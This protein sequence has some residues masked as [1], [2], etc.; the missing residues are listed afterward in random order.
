MTGPR[1]DPASPSPTRLDSRS[2][3]ARLTA[4]API[5]TLVAR[6]YLLRTGAPRCFPVEFVAA[7][8]L[9]APPTSSGEGV[10][11]VVLVDSDEQREAAIQAVALRAPTPGAR[12][13]IHVIPDEPWPLLELVGQH[14]AL[15]GRVREQLRVAREPAAIR[16]L[17]ARKRALELGIRA[18]L[19]ALLA[20]Y[21][22]ARWL[23]GE[24]ELHD[25]GE[26]P[27]SAVLSDICEQLHDRAPEP[28]AADVR[29]GRLIALPTP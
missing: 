16:E 15:D 13:I 21:T 17:R 1:R 23:L 6:R 4:L 11:R 26:R 22:G 9:A 5:R 12:P 7:E 29:I 25:I 2:A 10:V 14:V 24:R 28:G 20:G 19:K 27:T 8:G 18:E 3:A